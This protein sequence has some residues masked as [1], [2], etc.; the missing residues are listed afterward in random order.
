MSTHL[1]VR[2]IFLRELFHPSAPLVKE[3]FDLFS[4][5]SRR[6]DKFCHIRVIL[7]DFGGIM[8]KKMIPQETGHF[9][10]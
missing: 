3:D 5:N 4:Q 9:S 10:L 7:F 8:K 6:F 2:Q 1:L